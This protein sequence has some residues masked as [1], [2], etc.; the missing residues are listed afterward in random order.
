MTSKQTLAVK[1]AVDRTMA[2]LLPKCRIRRFP[3]PHIGYNYSRSDRS[4]TGVGPAF[5][6]SHRVQLRWL[7]FANLAFASPENDPVIIESRLRCSERAS[8]ASQYVQVA[9][10][11]GRS[12]LA[13]PAERIRGARWIQPAKILA[14]ARERDIHESGI[15]AGPARP[16]IT[17]TQFH[18]GQ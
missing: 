3:L 7:P 5:A 2:E 8:P 12:Q 10:G 6:T 16:A 15:V 17:K 18:V 14:R 9:A 4:S 13:T 1:A 11:H